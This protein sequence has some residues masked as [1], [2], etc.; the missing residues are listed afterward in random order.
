MSLE[1]PGDVAAVVDAAAVVVDVDAGVGVAGVEV[2]AVVG[3]G[4]AAEFDSV[5]DISELGHFASAVRFVFCSDSDHPFH[6]RRE[7]ALCCRRP[8]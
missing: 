1:W 6:G 4:V 8:V 3:A 5:L 7:R 2:G